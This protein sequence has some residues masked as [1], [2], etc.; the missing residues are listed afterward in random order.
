M[1]TVSLKYLKTLL[2]LC[3]CAVVGLHIYWHTLKFLM[4]KKQQ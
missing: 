2:Q 3:Q 4:Q 1:L